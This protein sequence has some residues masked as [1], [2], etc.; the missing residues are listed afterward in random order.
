MFSVIEIINGL[1]S[2]TVF[3][4]RKMAEKLRDKIL[5]KGGEAEL[6]VMSGVLR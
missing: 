6:L 2:E 1:P 3:E 4:C 5:A